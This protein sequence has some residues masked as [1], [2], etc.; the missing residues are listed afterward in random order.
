MAQEKI[1][2]LF[3]ARDDQ[4]LIKAVKDLHKAT[5]GLNKE[6]Q[7]TNNQNKKAS[8]STRKL[9]QRI[10]STTM[11]VRGLN[12]AFTQLQGSIAIYRNKAL[13]AS[14]ATGL[15]I[16]PLIRLVKVFAD[17]EDL[18]RGFDNLGRSIGASEE[19]LNKL[20]L[21]TDGT[22]NSMDL[23]RQANN[24]MMLGVVQ[25]EDEM[26]ELFDMAQRL[27]QALGRDTLTSIESLVT[28]MGRQSRLMLDNIGIIVRSEDAYKRFAAENGKLAK[29]LTDVEKKQAFNNEALRQGRDIV[30]NLGVE[31]LSTNAHISRMQVATFEISRTFGEVLA[32]ALV[33]ISQSMVSFSQ[34][35]DTK[36]VQNIIT[37]L[38]VLAGAFVAVKLGALRLL[39][40]AFK[41]FR[42]FESKGLGVLKK[43]I[44]RLVGFKKAQFLAANG[45][46]NLAK[47][48]MGLQLV[49]TG[50]VVV[51]K[52][53][54][55]ALFGSNEEF[56]K[57]EFLV[58]ATDE[59]TQQYNLNLKKQ[60][61]RIEALRPI[62][63]DLDSAYDSTT[64]GQLEAVEAQIKN[65]QELDKLQ[66]LN[67]S[68][69]KGL[70]ILIEKRD[71]LN[72]KIFESTEAG[73]ALAEVKKQEIQNFKDVNKIIEQSI[74]A[75]KTDED[76]I[77][78]KISVLKDQE[79]FL[80]SEIDANK[81]LANSLLITDEARADLNKTIKSQEEQLKAIPDAIKFQ[82]DELKKLDEEF[83]KNEAAIKR[84][85]DAYNN[86]DSTQRDLL[87]TQ[88]KYLE[89][90][91]LTKELSDDQKNG[92]AA[93]KKELADLDKK[94]EEST[95]T[96]ADFRNEG[97]LK[98]AESMDTFGTSMNLT[99]IAEQYK[100][101]LFLMREETDATKAAIME[102]SFQI[103]S[104]L[105]NQFIAASNRKIKAAQD[106]AKAR[107]E[108][109]RASRRF[110]K[111]TDAQRKEAEQDVISEQKKAVKEEFQIQQ[112]MA[113]AAVIMETAVAIMKASPNVP[114]Q[115]A[116]AALGAMQ[117]ANVNAQQPPK[118]AQGGLIGGRRHSEGGTLIEAEQGEFI[119][120]RNAVDAIGVE[121][122]NRMN[123]G[124]GAAVNVSFSGNVMSDDFIENEA[125]PKIREAVR[126]GSDIGVS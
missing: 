42:I 6:Y 102:M 3:T 27:G 31:V 118:M 51:F 20:Q 75:Q 5:S 70:D 38:V 126:R 55:N 36:A 100:E 68:Q 41:L 14:F 40:V 30:E 26:A 88:I 7:K 18:G 43:F 115:I 90:L 71:N 59:S 74:D 4:K 49:A 28:G 53:V 123:M 125:I 110:E 16:T 65:A 8:K 21:A 107:I 79:T 120:S 86:L 105:M 113:K 106:E 89:G 97:L 24:A 77:K 46:N 83:I 85:E 95:A 66:P 63:K 82:E 45:S 17:T 103:G 121:T 52:K 101:T 35:L 104:T 12:G 29:N 72:Q 23:M 80:K 81:N 78:D 91:A 56:E 108:A 124:A 76:K 73:K 64:E 67:E 61:E 87:D 119:M 25:S 84:S 57:Q 60:Q 11:S 99:E 22:V 111:M 50:A 19:H 44:G 13:L 1:E 34:A 92:L 96:A 112:Q 54:R 114:L 62:L 10:K 93:L 109:L 47:R 94:I 122:L 33:S 98:L 2:I 116:V 39:N 37:G 117:L 9:G 58:N 32:P 48:I 15:L 69:K